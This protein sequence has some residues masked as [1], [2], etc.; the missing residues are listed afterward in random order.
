[1]FSHS[2]GYHIGALVG[3]LGGALIVAVDFW[4]ASLLVFAVYLFIGYCLER[5][6]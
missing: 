6:R 4:P 2:N 5:S 1:M 3:L